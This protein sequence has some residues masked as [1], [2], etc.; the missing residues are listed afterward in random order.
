MSKNAIVFGATSGIGRELA[1]LL[2]NDGYKVMITGRRIERL[3][4]I[5]IENPDNY[6]AQQHDITDL[7]ASDE[8]FKKLPTIFDKVDLIVHNSGIATPNYNL[9]WD[10]D[11]PTIY[12]NVVGATKVYQLAYNYFA[13]QGQGHLVGVTS[14][15]SL[16]GNRQVPAYHASKAYQAS[17]LESLYMKSLRTKKAKI[18]VTEIIPGFVDTDIIMGKTYWMSSVDKAS[19]QI[20]TAI[21]KKKRKA[22]ITRRWRL[23]AFVLRSVSPKLYMKLM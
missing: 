21:K 5:K 6:I 20:Y 7:N 15:A 10:K 8:L 23:V 1:K 9:D 4:E 17:Y 12:T 13:A 14:V 18:N 22:Y 2:V 19:K 11:A 16:R 3:E